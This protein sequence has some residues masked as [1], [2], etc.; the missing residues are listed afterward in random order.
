MP[1]TGLKD[2]REHLFETLELLKDPDKPMSA[3]TGSAIAAVAKQ[4]IESAKLEL[5]LARMVG[6]A[7]PGGTFFELPVERE[8]PSGKGGRALLTA[9]DAWRQP[10]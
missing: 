8:L 3:Q 1:K 2:L 6:D 9:D 4:V 10:K 5:N 7:L